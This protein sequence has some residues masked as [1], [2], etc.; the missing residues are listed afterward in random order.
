VAHVVDSAAAR[1]FSGLV[2][3]ATAPRW[4]AGTPAGAPAPDTVL[5][6]RAVGLA[7]RTTGRPLRVD[8]VWRWASISK[9]VTAALVMQQVDAGRLTLETPLATALPAFAG[10]TARA[11]TIRHLLQHTSGLPNPDDS[12]A[13]GNGMPRFY[14]A[15]GTRGGDAGAALDYCGGAPRGAPGDGFAY[16]NCD[17]LVL[18]AVLE[19]V[20]ER[21]VAALVR[22]QLGARLGAATVRAAEDPDAAASAATAVR[23]YLADGKPEPAIDL[24]TFGAAGS[25]SGTARDLLRFDRALLAERLVSKA[26]TEAM[27]RGE[28]RLGYAALGAWAF[29]ARLR[30]CAGTVTLVERRGEIGGVQVRNVIAPALGRVL[31]VFTNDAGVRFGE[32]WQG[33]GLSHALLSAALCPATP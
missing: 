10:P 30:G 16:N 33:A 29:P 11:V 19:R 4:P 31:I 27:W 13:D 15:R 20:T 7:D 9:Q 18:G 8:D 24:A 6:E 1:G 12:P 17:Y 5:Y 28:A 3:V 26:S 22:E 14:Q 23:G 21:S 25:L 32:V 2:L